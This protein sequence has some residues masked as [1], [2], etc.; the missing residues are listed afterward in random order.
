MTSHM[1]I[2]TAEDKPLSVIENGETPVST[3]KETEVTYGHIIEAFKRWSRDPQRIMWTM[4][5]LFIGVFLLYF[6]LFFLDLMGTSFKVLG[7][8]EAG[9]MF[10]GLENPIAG[11]M[12]GILA[13]VCIQSS[14]T[15]TSI[16]VSLVGS[17]NMEVKTAIPVIMG[18]NIGTSVTNTIV[19]MFYI[20]QEE[21]LERAFSG[22]TVHDCFNILSVFVLLPIEIIT[23]VL[24]HITEALKPDEVDDGDKWEGPL[25]KL[26]SPLVS[27]LIIANKDVMT[28]ISKGET[29]CDAVYETHGNVDDGVTYIKGLIK[30]SCISTYANDDGA[31]VVSPL[32]SQLIIANKDVMTS[33]SKGET[34]CDAVYETHGNVDDGVTYIKGLIK[35]SCIS[36]YANDDWGRC[37][38]TGDRYTEPLF[39]DHDASLDED[40]AAAGVCL[41]IS[42][43]G[44]CAC[45]IFLVRL[46]NYVTKT[47]TPAML[48]KAAYMPGVV[49]IFVGTGLTILV[50]SS[51]V[52]T[53]VLTPLVAA[54]IITLAG[55]TIL[56]Q[57]SSVTTSV[58][59][60]LV[61]ADIITLEQ[62]LP[63][64]MG[65][66]IGTTCTALLAS[67]VS[68]KT[69]AVQIAL[70]HLLFNIFG[71]LIWYPIP[72]MRQIPLRAARFLG[73]C[74]KELKIFPII[75]TV[76]IFLLIPLVLF[77][78][79]S[80]FDGTKAY[81]ALGTLI[82]ITLLLLLARM[83]YWLKRQG[84][85]EIILEKVRL[86]NS[87]KDFF[88][89]LPEEIEELKSKIAKLEGKNGP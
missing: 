23:G 65:A 50:Q 74:T 3:D 51:S 28:S 86:Y 11:L 57:S 26:V 37:E 43:I 62:M 48:K 55:L 60:P 80:L 2:E 85:I 40:M 59:T 41:V 69:D 42:I 10:D 49:A 15:S 83:V 7:S 20:A 84:G 13:T 89:G 46:L 45:M 4:L 6:F 88:S 38:D 34:T 66:N 27:Q 30:A 71:I 33:I 77:G 1:E 25:K 73:S 53:S 78:I 44:L 70:C 24:R 35:A 81:E 72:F 61:A 58:L 32:V 82:V 5:R 18:A 19:S 21:D 79:S 56:V 39:Y 52:T 31:D 8:C 47:S 68:T 14:S 29:T 22:A 63:L 36:T 76:I 75:Y 12:V 16:V 64:T 67:L 17:G 9:E 54:D 87:R